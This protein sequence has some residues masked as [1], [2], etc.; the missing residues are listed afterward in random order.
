MKGLVLTDSPVTHYDSLSFKHPARLV[1]LLTNL[2][3]P[4][5]FSF[6][7]CSRSVT[8]SIFQTLENLL[9]CFRSPFLTLLLGELT[10][11]GGH[12]DK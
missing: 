1:P 7:L 8:L 9:C 6:L 3:I 12:F 10:V 2:V 4:K 5:E 11:V